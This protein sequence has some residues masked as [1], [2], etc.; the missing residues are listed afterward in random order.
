MRAVVLRLFAQSFGAAW[1]EHMFASPRPEDEAVESLFVPDPIGFEEFRHHSRQRRTSGAMPAH[2][3]S[4]APGVYRQPSRLPQLHPIS[5]RADTVPLVVQRTGL[6][7]PKRAAYFPRRLGLTCLTRVSVQKTCWSSRSWCCGTRLSRPSTCHS[8]SSWGRTRTT[9]CG[10][11]GICVLLYVVTL[12]D[13]AGCDWC[14]GAILRPGSESRH[15]DVGRAGIVL[16]HTRRLKQ[17][18]QQ[19]VLSRIFCIC[20]CICIFPSSY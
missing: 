2:R 10:G 9:R 16:L 14:Q 6:P 4:V 17:E 7:L 11:C 3:R 5:L 1:P 15:R 8:T 19:R 12:S 13:A 18:Q 20:I